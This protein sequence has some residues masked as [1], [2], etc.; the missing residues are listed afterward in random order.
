MS[1]TYTISEHL[2]ICKPDALVDDGVISDLKLMPN[3]ANDLSA[4]D[5]EGECEDA[6]YHVEEL[7]ACSDGIVDA[8]RF[9]E[10]DLLILIANYEAA[11]M[12]RLTPEELADYEH[13]LTVR[14]LKN[15]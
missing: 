6:E 10:N 5:F 15:E 8:Q 4:Y 13:E 14:A 9:L 11:I 2:K 3:I 7:Q 1:Q 12:E